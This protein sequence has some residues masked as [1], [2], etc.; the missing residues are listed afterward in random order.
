MKGDRMKNVI[1]VMVLSVVIALA[2]SSG[3]EEKIILKNEKEKMSYSL[4]A[5]FGNRLKSRDVEIDFEILM[6]GMKDAYAGKE[7]LMDK[8]EIRKNFDE[9]RNMK[10]SGSEKRIDKKRESKENAKKKKEEI[11][12]K[13]MKEGTAF[14]AANKNNNGVITRPSG[15]QY[16]IIKE[17]TGKTPTENG[18]VTVNYRGTLISGKE[19]DSSYTKKKP[20]TF[21]LK[22]VIKGWQEALL[23]MKEGAQWQLYV[24]SDLAYGQRG[25]G[26]VVGPNE[27]LIFDIELISVK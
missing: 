16:K 6:R 26:G 19:F 21:S 14:L 27:M 10:N 23:L 22:K 18:S 25:A 11:A 24:P 13:N 2:G 1:S 9:F 4:G 17:G 20:A 5:N 15:L 12:D 8:E 7:L 3:A